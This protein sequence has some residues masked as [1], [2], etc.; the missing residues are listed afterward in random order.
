MV[1][2]VDLLRSWVAFQYSA[3]KD[4]DDSQSVRMMPLSSVRFSRHGE[5]IVTSAAGLV[6][7]HSVSTL[8]AYPDA[9]DADSPYPQSAVSS[10]ATYALIERPRLAESGLVSVASNNGK[11]IFSGGYW[12]NSVKCHL[13]TS[14][15]VHLRVLSSVRAHHDVVTAI[16]LG[17]DQATLIT[18]SRDG[19]TALWHVFS[20]LHEWNRPPLA[21]PPRQP[22]VHVVHEGPVAVVAINTY[23]GVAVSVARDSHVD[24]DTASDCAVYSV[25]RE[26]HIRSFRVGVENGTGTTD[27]RAAEVGSDGSLVFY[28][29]QQGEPMLFVYSVNGRLLCHRGVQHAINTMYVSVRGDLLFTGDAASMVTVRRVHTLEVVHVFRPNAGLSKQLRTLGGVTNVDLEVNGQH[30]VVVYGSGHVCV[31]ELPTTMPPETLVGYYKKM[32][33]NTVQNVRDSLYEGFD[34][35]KE[36]AKDIGSKVID[37]LADTKDFAGTNLRKARAGLFN[38]IGTVGKFGKR[39]F[40]RGGGDNE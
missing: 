3:G 31:F 37:H 25:R 7:M 18:G 14:S 32:A 4:N 28:A 23:A 17:R 11:F 40:S 2:L 39:L 27:V 24:G 6:R 34:V 29:L 36:M 5:I 16:A 15:R 33:S 9:S 1:K 13:L 30:M 8:L 35:T 12:D 26:R 38:V 20:R 22:T 19:G 10:T 21:A